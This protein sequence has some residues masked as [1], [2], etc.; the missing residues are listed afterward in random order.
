MK[1][2]FFSGIVLVAIA[3]KFVAWQS[4]APAT[5]Y[6]IVDPLGQ[7]DLEIS[8]SSIDLGELTVGEKRSVDIQIVNRQRRSIRLLPPFADCGCLRSRLDKDEIAPGE[9]ATLSFDFRA[10]SRPGE[11]HKRIAV[12]AESSQL[13]WPIPVHCQVKA[14]VWPSPVRLSVQLSQSGKG[15]TWGSINHQQHQSITRVVASH[16]DVMDVRWTNTSETSRSFEVDI[17]DRQA[18]QGTLSFFG[19]EGDVPQA[20]VPIRWSPAQL[21]ACSPRHLVLRRQRG[22]PQRFQITVLS[23]AAKISGLEIVPAVD[24]IQLTNRQQLSR[25]VT[26]FTVVAN[27]RRMP[28]GF[29]GQLVRIAAMNAPH[30]THVSAKVEL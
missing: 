26:T 25:R 11:S 21:V 15:S 22:A 13:V 20:T 29:Q 27:V 3:G 23:D 30:Q 10:P 28:R 19:D 17:H 5:F 16:P 9:A 2:L 6:S 18:G 7:D 1:I 14:D 12:R 24:W 4:F 8:P